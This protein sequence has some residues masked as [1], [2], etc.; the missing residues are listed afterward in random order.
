M[1]Y[2]LIIFISFVC[3][4]C[5]NSTAIRRWRSYSNNRPIIGI[6]AQESN[7]NPSNNSNA[8]YYIAASYVKFVE[9][10]GA[11]VVPIHFNYNDEQRKVI[12][13]SIN[14]VLLPGGA[15]SLTD[16]LYSK[17]GKFIINYAIERNNNGDYFPIWATCL[18][19]ELLTNYL[20]PNYE[21]LVNCSSYDVA[22]P[23]QFT[24]S[25]KTS[26]LFTDLP[27][28]VYQYLTQLDVTANYHRR[29]LTPKAVVD[30]GLSDIINVLSTNFDDNNL[31][32]VSTYETIR[33]AQYFALFFTNEAR[34]NNHHFKDASREEFELI[35]NKNPLYT[36]KNGSVFEQ[37][38]IFN[39]IVVT[40]SH[41]TNSQLRNVDYITSSASTPK[42]TVFT[43]HFRSHLIKIPLIIFI[44]FYFYVVSL[45]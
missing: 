3:V 12:L 32:F 36:G 18:G 43:L 30:S 31:E 26:R 44:G 39:S 15:A 14:G 4:G 9:S 33:V 40:E 22:L 21:N 37:Q 38:Y 41:Q 42:S 6:L 10:G 13:D 11:R 19:F 5:L 34:K 17:V 7:L 24:S 8:T 35:Y 20:A 2:S 27:S 45:Y 1:K 23:L 16:S 25:A 28:D 29:C